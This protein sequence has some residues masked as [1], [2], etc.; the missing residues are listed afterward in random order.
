MTRDE[1]QA[2]AIT[3][4]KNAG[5]RATWSFCTG[6][7]K[8]KTALD[9]LE[10]LLAK[11]PD[12][13]TVII[14]PTDGLREQWY[15]K[16]D[17]RGLVF[18]IEVLIINTASSKPFSCDILI[19]DECH[20]YNSDS[21]R[22]V[23]LNCHPKAILGLT[24]TY[25][26]LDG[27]QKEVL[28]KICPVCDTVSV[29]EAIENNWLSPYREYK[30]MIDVDLTEYD[31]AN[32]TF[33]ST[34]SYFN[35]EWNKAMACVT[36]PSFR[37]KYA[38]SMGVTT[39]ELSQKAFAWNKAMQFRKSFIANHPRKIEIAQKILEA[40][41][42]KKCITFNGSIEQCEAYGSGYVLHSKKA[43]KEQ[44][45]IIE[46]FSHC[47]TGVMHT[48]KMADEGLDIPGL[49]V[50]IITGFNSS[51]TTTVQRTGR[52]IRYEKGK[53]AEVFF[54]V[55]KGCQDDKWFKKANEG[56]EFI[57]INEQELDF[58]LNRQELNKTVKVQ[59]SF[60]GFRF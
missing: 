2:L 47:D 39:K 9:A 7:G 8:T 12:A 15:T 45:K 6:F 42:D 57:E 48:S 24:A 34:F 60:N 35:F 49:S 5:C 27:K 13:R 26:R 56:M 10:R 31:K 20:K 19:L 54:L 41:K 14:V 58:I 28:D 25:E 17:E 59:S 40:R 29:Q 32:Q 43:K 52:V 33:L 1:R 51:K 4:W 22:K 50:A 53:E 46:E 38:K 16:L 21:F 30:V 3:N 55:L 11:N 44:R 36:D 18:N 23:F 37:A